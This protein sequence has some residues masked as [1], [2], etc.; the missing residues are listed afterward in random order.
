LARIVFMGTP[1]FAVPALKALKEAGHDIPLLVCQPDKRKGRGQKFQY[2]PTKQYALEAGIEVYQPAKVRNQEALEKLASFEADFFVVIAYG[3]ILPKALLDLPKK[4]CINVHASLLPKWRGAAPIQ[5]S[6][7]KGDQETGV[8]SMLMDEGMDTGDMLLVERTPIDPDETVDQLGDRL[9]SM[10]R[11]LIVKTVENFEAIQPKT[12]NHEQATYTRMI[13]KEDRVL[14]W[15]Q[16]ADAVYCQYRALSPSP[17][18]FTM[19]RG[20]R[21]AIKGMATCSAIVSGEPQKPGTI[22]AIGAESISV[23]CAAGAVN[24]THCQPEN[25]KALAVKDLINGYQIK[26]GEYLG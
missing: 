8:C 2:P 20:K 4:G 5:F 18:V 3:K 17:G 9:S 26:V 22:L 11:E 21:L 16:N 14:Q 7:W 15:D 6:L 23:A 19:F 12:Q 25:K 1:D 13:T 10:G 24:L